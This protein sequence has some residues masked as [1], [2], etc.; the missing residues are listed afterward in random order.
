[1]RQFYF[2]SDFFFQNLGDFGN[3]FD[4]EAMANLF[5]KLADIPALRNRVLA[6]I[7]GHFQIIFEI[8]AELLKAGEGTQFQ[9]A[10]LSDDL[11]SALEGFRMY[12]PV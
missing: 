6:H 11:W 8:L 10:Q 3:S 9:V 4:R 2:Y 5:P 1:V 12:H 7:F